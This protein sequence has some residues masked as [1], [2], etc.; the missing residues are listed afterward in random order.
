M[1]EGAEIYTVMGSDSNTAS[2]IFG[3][4]LGNSRANVL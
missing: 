1:W 4:C 2:H 3:K